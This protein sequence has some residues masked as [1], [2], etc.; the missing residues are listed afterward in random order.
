MILTKTT[1]DAGNL[2]SYHPILPVTSSPTRVEDFVIEVRQRAKSSSEAS[3]SL[4]YDLVA[5]EA[6]SFSTELLAKRL[7]QTANPIFS[8]ELLDEV[9]DLLKQG[10]TECL[11][12][13]AMSSKTRVRL[14]GNKRDPKRCNPEKNC[15][16]EI[17]T[18]LPVIRPAYR[19]PFD[20]ASASE[21]ARFLRERRQTGRDEMIASIGT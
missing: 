4:Y 17:R 1:I 5:V 10:N 20:W 2:N 8:L 9:I 21:R 3:S 7:Y 13:A 14:L 11:I 15:M 19:R 16:V 12:W 6:Y 18:R